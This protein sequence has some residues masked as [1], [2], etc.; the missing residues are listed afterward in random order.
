MRTNWSYQSGHPYLSYNPVANT[1]HRYSDSH[2]SHGVRVPKVS[3]SSLADSRRDVTMEPPSDHLI[4]SERNSA[5]T[6]T[7]EYV[8]ENDVDDVGDEIVD[9]YDSDVGD[10]DVGDTDPIVRRGTYHIQKKRS[11]IAKSLAVSG[12]GAIVDSEPELPAPVVPEP[13]VIRPRPG[14]ANPG[15]IRL[16]Y[17]LGSNSELLF[18]IDFVI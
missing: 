6:I 13:V 1:A 9:P 7:D 11:S 8:A 3:F 17:G 18:R 4:N 15:P 14:L 16:V 10:T 12:E 5:Y 2:G